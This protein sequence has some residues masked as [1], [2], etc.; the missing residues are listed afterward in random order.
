MLP[1]LIQVG[2]MPHGIHPLR[3]PKAK[4]EAETVAR[5]T[6]LQR[7]NTLPGSLLTTPTSER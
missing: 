4:E 7:V 6:L 5:V 2:L 1:G 3:R